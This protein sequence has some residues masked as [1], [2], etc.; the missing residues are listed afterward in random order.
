MSSPCARDLATCESS[1]KGVSMMLIN[2]K[3][4][5][6]AIARTVSVRQD[7]LGMLILLCGM[8]SS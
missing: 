6:L 7:I 3:D 1:I 5:T 8:I 2:I 4:E